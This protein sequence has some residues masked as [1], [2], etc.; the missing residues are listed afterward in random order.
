MSGLLLA[1]AVVVVACFPGRW[2]CVFLSGEICRWQLLSLV[3]V[4]RFFDTPGEMPTCFALV[5]WV[6]GVGV[7]LWPTHLELDV[8]EGFKDKERAEE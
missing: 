5:C 3:W 2:R 1:A 8:R 7:G 4:L 6:L